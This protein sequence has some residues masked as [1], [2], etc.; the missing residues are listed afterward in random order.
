MSPK[1][2]LAL[3]FGLILVLM[4]S[5]LAQ[6]QET[7]NDGEVRGSIRGTVTEDRNGDGRCD[8]AEDAAVV[9]IPI[10]FTSTDGQHILFLQSGDDGTY[11]LVAAG[12]GTWTVT[13]RPPENYVATSNPV[14]QVTL[15]AEQGLVTGVD[16]C[17]RQR[18]VPGGPM[19]GPGHGGPMRP[20]GPHHPP[21]LL[22]ESGAAG[23]SGSTGLWIAGLVGVLFVGVGLVLSGRNRISANQR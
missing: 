14:R 6:A 12:L 20:P 9:G 21:V 16:Y 23:M 11:G 13:V 10:E 2:R 3:A 22:P 15:T 5:G 18:G 4:G 19:G 7:S 17:V 1:V 8:G